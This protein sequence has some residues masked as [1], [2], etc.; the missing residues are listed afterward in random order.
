MPV[1]S[2]EGVE[3]S[4]N[5]STNQGSTCSARVPGHSEVLLPTW[6]HQEQLETAWRVQP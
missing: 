3:P 5:G 4:W 6:D 2:N 1:Y